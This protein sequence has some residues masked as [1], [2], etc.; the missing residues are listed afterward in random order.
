MCG[1]CAEGAPVTGEGEYA[2][3]KKG[4]ERRKSEY[5]I[6][7]T[8]QYGKPLSTGRL[9]AARQPKQLAGS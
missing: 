8:R 6:N 2:S 9:P 4:A 5:N 3:P 7:F 1:A